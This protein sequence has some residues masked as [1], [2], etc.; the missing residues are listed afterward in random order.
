MRHV[1]TLLRRELAAYFLSP[2]AYLILL[3]FQAIAWLDFWQLVETLKDRQVAFSGLADPMTLYIS[4]STPF[5]VALLVAVPALT[6]RL[7]AEERR[8]GTIEP[9]LTVPVTETEVTLA[10][11]LAGVVMFWVLLLPFAIYLPF[12]R[13]F[14]HFDFDL[15]PLASLAIGLTTMGMMFV[16]IGLFFSALTKN[17]I[18][19]AVAT[20]AVLFLLLVVTLLAGAYGASS[21]AGWTDAVRFVSV[22]DQA[23]AF[24]WGKLDPRFLALHLSVTVLMLFGTVKALELRRGA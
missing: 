18:V 4:G 5:W 9:L 22:L 15:G 14:G 20:F 17:Q 10:K 8:V 23:Q 6:M 1:P 3:A 11:W 12:L 2:M 19:A 7:V 21:R 24:A 13:H 16:S